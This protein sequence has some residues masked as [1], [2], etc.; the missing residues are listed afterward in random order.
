M[1]NVHFNISFEA[2]ARWKT[3]A[4]AERESTAATQQ[5]K[6]EPNKKN[7]GDN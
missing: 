4:N 3:A 7:S 2:A 5:E 1:L 6:R